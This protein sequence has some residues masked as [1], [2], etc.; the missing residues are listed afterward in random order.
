MSEL[1]GHFCEPSLCQAT[2]KLKYVHVSAY[3]R[4]IYK[5]FWFLINEIES[6]KVQDN[7]WHVR[8]QPVLLIISASQDLQQSSV[9]AQQGASTVFMT[10]AVQDSQAAVG[11]VCRPSL[12]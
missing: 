11:V 12:R 8:L 7:L 9:L 4:E 1:N 10:L 2:G 6:Q 3:N 5:K